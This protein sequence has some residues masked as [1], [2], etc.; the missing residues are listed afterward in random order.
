MGFLTFQLFFCTKKILFILCWLKTLFDQQISGFHIISRVFTL[1]GISKKP[2]KKPR[3]G[4]FKIH[5]FWSLIFIRKALVG[6][7]KDAVV[8]RTA[9][10]MKIKLRI[11]W[12][13]KKRSLV[14]FFHKNVFF[15]DPCLYPRLFFSYY[16][17]VFLN[18]RIYL[19]TSAILIF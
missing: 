4:F 2:S 9:F 11:W 7:R 3:L 14:F 19:K 12:I 10:P 17:Y 1:F 13:L 16:N 15:S 5:Q 6:I 18:A 8:S